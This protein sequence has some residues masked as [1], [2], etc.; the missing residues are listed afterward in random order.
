MTKRCVLYARVSS[1]DTRRDGRNLAGQLEMCRDYAFQ[2]GWEIVAEL[3]EDDRG[4]SGASLDL[5]QLNRMLEMAR[6]REIDV[7]VVR[8]IDRFS[9]TLAKQLIIEEQLKRSRVEIAYVLGEYPNT[10]E[11]NLMKNLKASI[12]EYE[13]LKITE[14]MTRGRRL[15]ARAGNVVSH[16]KALFGYR[17]VH[18]DNKRRLEICE[19]E[20]QTVRL[21][22]KW[23]LEGDDEFRP[24][25][26][27]AIARKLTTLRVPTY[28]DRRNKKYLKK[29]PEGAWSSQSVHGILSNEAYAGLWTYS[30]MKR[31]DGKCV[32][33]GEDELVKVEIPAIVCRTRWE[34][35]QDRL[36]HNAAF[37]RKAPKFSYLMAQRLVCGECGCSI[38]GMASRRSKNSD[39]FNLYYGCLARRNHVGRECSV[40]VYFRA[41]D[42]DALVWEWITSILTDPIALSEGIEAYQAQQLEIQ[43][44]LEERLA[45]VDDLLKEHTTELERLLDLYLSGEFPRAMLA[46]RKTRLEQTIAS[47]QEE[48]ARLAAGLRA[49]LLSKDQ[50]LQVQDFLAEV[51]EGLQLAGD[52][53]ES[54]RRIIEMLDVRGT[55]AIEDGQKVLYVRCPIGANTFAIAPHKRGAGSPKAGSSGSE[56]GGGSEQSLLSETSRSSS[57]PCSAR[58][59]SPVPTAAASASTRRLAFSAPRA[60]VPVA[61]ALQPP[62]ALW[63]EASA[64]SQAVCLEQQKRRAVPGRS[65][66]ALLL[67]FKSAHLDGKRE[68]DGDADQQYQHRKDKHHQVDQPR[69]ELAGN[70]SKEQHRGKHYCQQHIA[71]GDLVSILSFRQLSGRFCRPTS[72]LLALGELIVRH[73]KRRE[74]GVGI[75]QGLGGDPGVGRRLQRR[76][77]AL[78]EEVGQHVVLLAVGGRPLDEQVSVEAGLLERRVGRL[79]GLDGCAVGG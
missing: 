4:A 45:V 25:S 3:S 7:V 48:K 74:R 56:T 51:V 36:Q 39:Q 17:L 59:P 34:R 19:E 10:P 32:Y 2:R 37:Y 77:K 15:Q 12:A 55:L 62:A 73:G 8:E 5:P 41:A 6:A 18:E 38:S 28:A 79:A 26:L 71:V 24:M 68:R 61:P 46:E 64:D 31:V 21:I 60:A 72:R 78:V 22:Y 27:N 47:L 20:A 29:A 63:A 44:P 33:N 1:D 11:G 40:R 53:F 16:G 54:R 42:V 23:Y 49:T 57:V 30:K 69:L 70:T 14:R 76:R 75:L 58:K 50:S 52:S 66:A 13:R 43:K 9:R 35:A 65:S 67:Y